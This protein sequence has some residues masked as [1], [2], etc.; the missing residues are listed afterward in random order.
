MYVYNIIYIRIYTTYTCIFIPSKLI[1][2][3]GFMCPYNKRLLKKRNIGMVQKLKRKDK[4]GLGLVWST[5]C[6][7]T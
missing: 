4:D 6:C 1:L 5:Q 7:G 2:T 3:L